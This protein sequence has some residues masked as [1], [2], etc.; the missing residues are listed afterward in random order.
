MI[1]RLDMIAPPGH[2][3][4]ARARSQ[5]PQNAVRKMLPNIL[6][7]SVNV[8]HPPRKIPGECVRQQGPPQAAA[9]RLENPCSTAMPTIETFHSLFLEQCVGSWVEH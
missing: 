6:A 2:Q 7:N 8:S 4:R 1:E 5:R 9:A 3:G